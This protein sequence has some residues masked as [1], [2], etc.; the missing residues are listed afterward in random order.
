ML[1][2]ILLSLLRDP[3]IIKCGVEIAVD[4]SKMSQMLHVDVASHLGLGRL[5]SANNM[6]P[7]Q[8][9]PGLKRLASDWASYDM[10]MKK[11]KI[12]MSDWRQVYR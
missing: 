2:T 1:P 4:V 6:Y 9:Q 5:S 8:S 11:K 10:T 7:N 3:N 12:T